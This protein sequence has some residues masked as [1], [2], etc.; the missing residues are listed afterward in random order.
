MCTIFWFHVGVYIKFLWN[1]KYWIKCT[2]VIYFHSLL[3]FFFDKDN[4]NENLFQ[5]GNGQMLQ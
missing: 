4:D 3:T 5:K 1:K 2:L